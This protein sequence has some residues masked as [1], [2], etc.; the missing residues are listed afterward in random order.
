MH[1]D[2]VVQLPANEQD[3][4][5]EHAKLGNGH[6]PFRDRLLL[7]DESAVHSYCQRASP[8]IKIVRLHARAV[9]AM[10]GEIRLQ[11]SARSQRGRV[12][13]RAYRPGPPR[14]VTLPR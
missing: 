11:L 13:D 3:Q 1:G 2:R 7:E 12:I 4:E 8:R 5:S 14:F 6:H 10:R 9:G